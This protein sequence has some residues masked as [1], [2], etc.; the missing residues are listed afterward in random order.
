MPEKPIVPNI[1]LIALT[2]MR[3]SRGWQLYLK[4]ARDH[5][6]FLEGKMRNHLRNGKHEEA[7]CD[8]AC[9]EDT[10]KLIE[11]F[12]NHYNELRKGKEDGNNN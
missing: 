1:N 2:E 7:R 10:Q 12:D 4:F 8:L 3:Q 5:C 11:L 9:F 6:I